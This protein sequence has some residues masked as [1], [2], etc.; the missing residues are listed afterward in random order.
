MLQ[1]EARALYDVRP[2]S[3]ID[4]SDP[5][6]RD[7]WARVLRGKCDFLLL[8]Y[9]PLSKTRL[10]VKAK[11]AGGPE[12]LAPLL[13][14]DAVSYAGLRVRVGGAE[15]FVF[16][17]H[18]GVSVGA[19]LRGKAAMHRQDAE[20]FFHGTAAGIHLAEDE[21]TADAICTHARALLGGGEISFP[22]GA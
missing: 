15:K 16:V 21:A 12:Q 6:L 11:G 14:D 22:S 19:M 5:T 8:T 2:A 4:L 7:A 20:S 1:G 10:A 18:V 13:A 3:D 17:A 9:A